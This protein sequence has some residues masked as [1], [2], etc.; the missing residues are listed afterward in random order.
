MLFGF[1]QTSRKPWAISPRLFIEKVLNKNTFFI[2]RFFLI[3]LLIPS[4]LLILKPLTYGNYPDFYYYYFATETLLNRGNPYIETITTAILPFS[5]LLYAY[6]PQSFFLFLPLSLVPFTVAGTVFVMLSTLSFVLSI[7]ILFKIFSLKPLSGLG[8]LLIILA[9]NFFP[10]KFTLGMGQVNNFVLMLVVLFIYF[11]VNKRQ[12]LSG[13]FLSLAVLIKVSP[14]VLFA[15]I[16]YCKKWKIILTALTFGIIISF[17]T[18]LF[19]GQEVFLY[20][21]LKTLPKLMG[22]WPGDYYNQSLSGFILRSGGNAD[23]FPLLRTIITLFLVLISLLF[24]WVYSKNNKQNLLGIN[25]LIILS[26]IIS[27]YSWQHHFVWALIPLVITF[28]TVK[29]NNLGISYYLILILS[30]LL[31]AINLK[32][33]SMVPAVLQSHVFYGVVLLYILNIKLLASGKETF[34]L[35][36]KQ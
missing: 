20:Y 5:P 32:D 31:M 11:L 2:V 36:N 3:L 1:I 12:V 33:P 35:K 24:I 22:A 10:A 21:F 16:I 9:F 18:Y 26:L 8:I 23:I 13:L 27:S 14:V 7:I 4:A 29:N 25:I 15:Y 30:Y 19:V 6:P 17:I 28:F 34:V